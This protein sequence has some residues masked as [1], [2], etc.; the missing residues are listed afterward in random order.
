MLSPTHYFAV[1]KCAQ[2]ILQTYA[3]SA[4]ANNCFDSNGEVV[5]ITLVKNVYTSMNLTIP[6]KSD[7]V[8]FTFADDVVWPAG[9]KY[10]ATTGILSGTPTGEGIQDV[11]ATFT[12]DTWVTNRKATFKFNVVSDF[13]LDGKAISDATSIKVQSGSAYS[14]TIQANQLYYGNQFRYETSRGASNQ[15]I[16]NSYYHKDE[17]TWYSRDEDKSAADIITLG[18]IS[19]ADMANSN[20]YGYTVTITKDGQAVTSG[21]TSELVNTMEMGWA[22]RSAYEV[23]TGVKLNVAA[24]AAAGTY[25]V[26]IAL[27]VPYVSKSTN[28]W[29][30][31]G[32]SNFTYSQTITIV[33]G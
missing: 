32:G 11:S 16:M 14:G 12:A 5:E 27:K 13:Q 25:T 22:G 1:R 2:R 20:I 24:D 26:T 19:N 8:K 4:V 15:R 33:V 17:L 28:P 7:D 6:G 21:V 23:N 30:R 10:D 31:A 29:M 18:D 9:M 3:N